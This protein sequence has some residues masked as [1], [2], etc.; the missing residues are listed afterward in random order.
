MDKFYKNSY[1]TFIIKIDFKKAKKINR[2]ITIINNYEKIKNINLTDKK[3][4]F[5]CHIKRNFEKN[6][7]STKL[8]TI[9]L[10][11]DLKEKE[12]QIKDLN[13]SYINQKFIDNLNGKIKLGTILNWTIKDLLESCKLEEITIQYFKNILKKNIKNFKISNEDKGINEENFIPMFINWLKKEKEFINKNIINIILDQIK[14]KEYKIKDNMINEIFKKNLIRENDVDLISVIYRYSKDIFETYLKTFFSITEN[15]NFLTTIFINSFSCIMELNNKNDDKESSLDDDNFIKN[16]LFNNINEKYNLI[17]EPTENVNNNSIHINTSF[18][19]YSKK[20]K[21]IEYIINSYFSLLSLNEN[22][23]KNYSLNINLNYQIPGFYKII[24]DIR[25]YINKN[26][27]NNYILN[28]KI[29]RYSLLTGEKLNQL[30]NQFHDDEKQYLDY[31]YN[32]LYFFPLVQ[33]ILKYE[34]EN[35]I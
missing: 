19:N 17:I 15:N 25:S 33:S 5:T 6:R 31:A 9:S 24:E 18:E 23:D 11:E 22:L 20:N 16:N 35:K 1:D 12:K 32:I 13:N 10:A 21:I 4:I 30:K 26:I 7:K 2:L 3:F 14:Y 8:L 28:E 34:E 29:L 27:I